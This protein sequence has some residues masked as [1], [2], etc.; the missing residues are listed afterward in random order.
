ME[1]ISVE[2]F[3]YHTSKVHIALYL[4]LE[5][6]SIYTIASFVLQNVSMI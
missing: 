3:C 5:T 6:Q 2:L 1:T 4:F